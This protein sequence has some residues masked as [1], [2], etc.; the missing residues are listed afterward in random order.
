MK[1]ISQL[2]VGMEQLNKFPLRTWEFNLCGASVLL[3]SILG[4]LII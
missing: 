2:C 4:T 3:A 1:R